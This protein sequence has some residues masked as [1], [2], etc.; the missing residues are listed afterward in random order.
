MLS[1]GGGHSNITGMLALSPFGFGLLF[2]PILG[3]L[4]CDLRSPVSRYVFLCLMVMHYA[5]LILY[6]SLTWD[7]EIHALGIAL[8]YMNFVV[9]SGVALAIYWVGQLFLW[10]AF[11]LA[12]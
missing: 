3:W 2:W 5:G 4:L 12:R 9:L 1:S 6:L 10:R 8:G 11:S 7:D